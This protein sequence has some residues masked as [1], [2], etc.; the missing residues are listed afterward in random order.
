MKPV[1]YSLRP[2]M[3]AVRTDIR[4]ENAPHKRRR[5]LVLPFVLGIVAGVGLAFVWPKLQ[6]LVICLQDLSQN[7][8]PIKTGM[9]GDDEWIKLY[10][11][12]R[13]RIQPNLQSIARFLF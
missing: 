9:E 5:R 7:K 12:M 13:P 11:E 3:N 6:P 1:N 2:I 4:M 8:F 10:G